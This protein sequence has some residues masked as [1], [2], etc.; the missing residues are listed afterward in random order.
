MALLARLVLLCA[1][2]STA[3]AAEQSPYAAVLVAGSDD[4]TVFDR[5]VGAMR[6]ALL[7][8]DEAP[9]DIHPFS[10]L[11]LKIDGTRVPV[12]RLKPILST[13]AA[14]RPAPGQACLVYITSHG[15]P[16]R[17][18][19]LA[20][21]EEFLT[22]AALDRA[23]AK[24]CAAAPTIVI[25]SGCYAGGFARAPMARPNRIILTAARADRPSFGC[26]ADFDYTVYDK[27]LLWAFDRSGGWRALYDTVRACVA[28][29]EKTLDFPASGPRASFGAAAGDLAI[30]AARP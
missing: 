30:P 16:G 23:L 2:A 26:G 27:C 28:E 3:A 9:A 17:G 29:A 21:R 18:L 1:L 10:A 14:L 11:N 4:L 25:A 13:I 15:A 5:A 20:P 22:P 8:R 7:A 19:F 6:G 24:G 12:A